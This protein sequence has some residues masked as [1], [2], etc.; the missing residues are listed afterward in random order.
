M[1]RRDA[2]EMAGGLAAPKPRY[3]LCPIAVESF[4][5]RGFAD[6]ATYQAAKRMAGWPLCGGSAD[7]G[8]IYFGENLCVDCSVVW[9]QC[10]EGGLVQVGQVGHDKFMKPI[11]VWNKGVWLGGWALSTRKSQIRPRQ[12][13]SQWT[14]DRDEY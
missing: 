2:I 12:F 7:P 1:M 13:E 14:W 8:T 11:A 10:L 3:H 6:D 4:T 9:D 5:E